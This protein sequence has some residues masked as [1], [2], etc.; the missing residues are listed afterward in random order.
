MEQHA[1]QPPFMLR[2]N[3]LC[4]HGHSLPACELPEIDEYSRHPPTA[5]PTCQY[6]GHGESGHIAYTVDT[7]P[8]L[9]DYATANRHVVAPT[10]IL[11]G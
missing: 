11:F 2:S 10:I 5:L 7:L 4:R 3:L 9:D 8:T 6:I 1:K